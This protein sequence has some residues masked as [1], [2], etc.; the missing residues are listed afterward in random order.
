MPAASQRRL[1]PHFVIGCHKRSSEGDGSLRSSVQSQLSTATSAESLNR[2]SAEAHH[3]MAESWPYAG[4]GQADTGGLN[5]TRP[6]RRNGRAF[7]TDR[8]SSRA[9]EPWC[10]LRERGDMIFGGRGVLPRPGTACKRDAAVAQ[11]AADCAA[12][13]RDSESESRYKAPQVQG[14]E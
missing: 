7:L 5:R 1:P 2:R 4:L 9:T 3:S 12:G 14:P 8:E 10:A 13:D 6:G 11:S